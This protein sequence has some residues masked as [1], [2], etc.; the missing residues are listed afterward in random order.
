MAYLRDE[1]RVASWINILIGIWLILAPFAFGFAN[2][3]AA[4]WNSIG[5]GAGMLIVAIIRA[6]RPLRAAPLNWITFVLGLWL[7]AS[8]FV[9]GF[10]HLIG[11]T[12]AHVVVGI[13]VAALSAGSAIGARGAME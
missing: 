9:L 2:L 3:Q 12:L 5:V 6:V 11:A 7:I 1:L 10:S 4:T 8:P 13:A